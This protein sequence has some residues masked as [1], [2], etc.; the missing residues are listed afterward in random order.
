M[1]GNEISFIY[2]SDL[3]EA[4]C[5]YYNVEVGTYPNVNNDVKIYSYDSTLTGKNYIS[6]LAELFGGNAKIQRDG[7]CSIIPLKN[8]SNITINALTSK[9]FEVGDTYE[10][11]RVCYEG[12]DKFFAPANLN[13]ITVEE[14][15]EENINL[16][17]Y[18]YLTSDMK[19]YKYVVIENEQ[20]QIERYEWQVS[21][22]IKNTLYIR[23]ENIFISNQQEI[24]NI[25]NEVLGFKITNIKCDNRM[26]LSLDSWDIVTYSVGIDTYNTLYDNVINF[27]G[28]AMG[29]VNVQ[30]PMKTREETT[31][32]V[33]D[34][35][36]T[37][38]RSIRRTVD[39]QN[40][41]ITERINELSDE[42]GEYSERISNVE[43]TTENIYTKNEIDETI[44]TIN[45]R[46]DG[47]TTTVKTSGGNN[48]FYYSKDFWSDGTFDEY[49]NPNEAN[50][51]EYIN[52]DIRQLSISQMGYIINNGVS[53]QTIDVKN[54]DNYTISFMYKKIKPLATVSVE[55][56]GVSY[57]LEE[58]DWTEFK[59]TVNI[60]TKTIDF[61][62]ISDTDEAVLIYDLLC[63]LGTEKEI[64]TQNANETRTDTVQI[65]KGIQ[66]NSSVSGIYTRI[67]ND[68]NRIFDNND[69]VVT[70][71]TD[72]GITT[73]ELKAD[74]AEIDGILIQTV[75]GQTW[76]SSLL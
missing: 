12:V 60:T 22:D 48:L 68:G 11:T 61:K 54:D 29:T 3:F 7:S 15:P 67:D 36:D 57:P 76:I 59:E 43:G 52:D 72:K 14:L 34:P 1:L 45:N 32:I 53:E 13:V 39:L 28:I 21:E 16:G 9:K 63:N 49:D 6:F 24:T 10:L 23:A 44:A 4:I 62:I 51:E 18:Y 64:W 33:G 47:I 8:N 66:V 56:N 58:T 19:Y 26:D 74:K 2:A 25:A 55:I 50:L 17:L 5:G 27:N 30:L 35:I 38:I 65:G 31:N 40:N 71:M 46:I 20:G 70:E 75:N 37:K 42:V 41:V 73:K 69:N